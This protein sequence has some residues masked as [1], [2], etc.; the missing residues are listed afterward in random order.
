[1]PGHAPSRVACLDQAGDSINKS[2]IGPE[3]A[4]VPCKGRWAENRCEQ[5]N[6]QEDFEA[7][8]IAAGHHNN[9]LP[10]DRVPNG[11]ATRL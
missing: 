7:Y 9:L 8:V 4:I 5:E 10:N 2:P 11:A 1:M 3:T 6:K